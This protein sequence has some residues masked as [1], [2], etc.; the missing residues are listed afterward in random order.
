MPSFA[1]VRLMLCAFL[2][3]MLPACATL[4]VYSTP[5]PGITVEPC[6]RISA[7]APF[8]PDPHGS[9]LALAHDGLVLLDVPTG[10]ITQLSEDAPLALAWAPDG[11]RLAAVLGGAEG[12]RVRIYDA[13][14]TVLGTGVVPG[15]A[16]ALVWHG[17]E[18][19]LVA[20]LELKGYSF[21]ANY[22]QLLSRWDGRTP[23]VTTVLYDSTLRAKTV[24]AL[25]P[26]LPRFFSV[27]LSPFG[28]AVVY[29]RLQDPPAFSPRLRFVV[30]N[31]ATGGEHEAA[32]A[33]VNSGG[34]IFAG[35][36]DVLW[37]GDGTGETAQLDP[38]REQRLSMLPQPGASLAASPGG[39][40]LFVDGRLYR[41]GQPF[42]TFP[43]DATGAFTADGTRLFVRQDDRIY[44]VGGLPPDPPP[45]VPAE[46]RERFMTLRQ[47]RSDGL[48]TPAEFTGA[49]ESAVRP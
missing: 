8:A 28:D 24:K 3:Q 44:L 18:E 39:T 38:W 27:A 12:S 17:N 16:S 6:T 45:A 5:P 35:R 15:T 49:V 4:P 7:G 9:R 26:I 1:P 22:K 37:Y 29:A 19:L 33:T 10:R 21:G 32:S 48:I 13:A 23:P 30:R 11:Q 46:R 25:S 34:A 14:G 47:W 36:D 41:N 31:L 2:L 43:P 42:L 20:S 40:T